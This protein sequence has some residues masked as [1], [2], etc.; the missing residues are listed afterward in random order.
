[1]GGY[2]TLDGVPPL[3]HHP[4]VAFSAAGVPLELRGEFIPLL[5]RGCGVPPYP[6]PT[7]GKGYPYG[8]YGTRGE[9]PPPPHHPLMG[10]DPLCRSRFWDGSGQ[11]LRREGVVWRGDGGGGVPHGEG[12]P[13]SGVTTI[14]TA[15][16]TLRAQA[17][18]TLRDPF[19]PEIY[20][21][22]RRKTY[23]GKFRRLLN[24]FI[25]STVT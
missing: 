13:P 25:S 9:V 2:G 15:K 14:G 22:P 7:L 1:M 10:G 18:V 6:H 23:S 5:Y 16:V 12:Y 17:P 20:P 19:H 11:G 21:L 24:I 8:G 3:P 4:P